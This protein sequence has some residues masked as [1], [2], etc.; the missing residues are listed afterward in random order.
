[1]LSEGLLK[2]KLSKNSRK[3]GIIHRIKEEKQEEEEK[4]QLQLS[5]FPVTTA[6]KYQVKM[7]LPCASWDCSDRF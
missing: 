5:S 3:M 6:V 7:K 4:K 1:L 2:K